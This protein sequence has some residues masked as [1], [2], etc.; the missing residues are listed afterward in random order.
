MLE[1]GDTFE[2]TPNNSGQHRILM[3]IEYMYVVFFPTESSLMAVPGRRGDGIMV[4]GGFFLSRILWYIFYV[5]LQERTNFLYVPIFF[6]GSAVALTN[7]R[8][9]ELE[10]PRLL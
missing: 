9:R 4:A 6:S 2:A 5:V 8:L 3:I 7:T 1:K 10:L